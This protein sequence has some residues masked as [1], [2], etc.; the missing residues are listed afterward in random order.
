MP[1]CQ[2]ASIETN[3]TSGAIPREVTARITSVVFANYRSEN[4][5]PVL[6]K[7]GANVDASYDTQVKYFVHEGIE[8]IGILMLCPNPDLKVAVKTEQPEKVPA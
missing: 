4:P 7:I 3:A 1:R 8:Y 2:N 5:L 6:L